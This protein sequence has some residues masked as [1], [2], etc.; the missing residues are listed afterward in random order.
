MEDFLETF[1]ELM[2]DI[3]IKRQSDSN[4]GYGRTNLEA[5]TFIIKGILQ[6]PSIYKRGSDIETRLTSDKGR[7]AIGE[8][9]LITNENLRTAQNGQEDIVIGDDGEYRVVSKK[10]YDKLIEH[11][12]Y[13][14]SKI[15]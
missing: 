14:C 4:I 5:E 2:S 12:E 11:F 15:V 8:L 3:T 1:E 10:K 6:A 7:F 13:I 9:L